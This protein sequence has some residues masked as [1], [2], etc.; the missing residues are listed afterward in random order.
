MRAK[1]F[2]CVE[3]KRPAAAPSV[4][5]SPAALFLHNAVE[6]CSRTSRLS[7]AAQFAWLTS[8][9]RFRQRFW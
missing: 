4:K 6:I 7:Q 2:D 8:I 5:Y 9:D 3:M 1:A